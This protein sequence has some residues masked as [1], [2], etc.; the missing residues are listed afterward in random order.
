MARRK[1]MNGLKRHPSQYKSKSPMLH[2]SFMNHEHPHKESEALDNVYGNVQMH[3]DLQKHIKQSMNKPATS[4]STSKKQ[5]PK[6]EI[7]GAKSASE[8][9]AKQTLKRLTKSAVN[10][11]PT[12]GNVTRSLS[13]YAKGINLAAMMFDPLSAGEGSTLYTYKDG[14]KYYNHGP[15]KGQEVPNSGLF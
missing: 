15:N 11:M 2:D 13:K 3:P 12:V 9:V 1:Y 10:K 14:K 6:N 4:P 8:F 5:T 7:D